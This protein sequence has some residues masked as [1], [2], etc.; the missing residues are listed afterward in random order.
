MSFVILMM[1]NNCET[2]DEWTIII[3]FRAI[4]MFFIKLTVV[5]PL[6]LKGNI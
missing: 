4:D 2:F 1:F 6:V 3:C 5:A